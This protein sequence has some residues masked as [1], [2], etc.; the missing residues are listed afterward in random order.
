V[1]AA[2]HLTAVSA[3]FTGAINSGSTITG[4]VIRT[5]SGNQRIQM[6]STYF[7]QYNASGNVLY[8]IGNYYN[9][10]R[11]DYNDPGIGYAQ[12][13]I[14]SFN[15]LNVQTNNFPINI[16]AGSGPL[17]LHGNSIDFGGSPIT[18]TPFTI[19][20]VSGLEARLAYL[21]NYAYV[22][23]HRGTGQIVFDSKNTVGVDA[24]TDAS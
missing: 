2:G 7:T 5:S 15:G 14:Y 4:A 18:G 21:E 12:A 13:S 11:T 20:N 6:D 8:Q 23:S 19:T 16:D 9:Y 1:D 3:N 17:Y 10:P 24:V 22:F